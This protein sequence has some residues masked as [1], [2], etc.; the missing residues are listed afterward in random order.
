M[1]IILMMSAKLATL[2]LFRTKIFRNKDNDVIIPDYDITS[3]TL[4]SGSNDIVDV[5]M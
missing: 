1:V 2:G 3:K 5:V 4:S